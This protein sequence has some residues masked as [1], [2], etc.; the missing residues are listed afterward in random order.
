MTL[1]WAVAALA[2][3]WVVVPGV[4][5]LLRLGRVDLDVEVDDNPG[6]AEPAGTNAAYQDRFRALTALGFR[7][8]GMTTEKAR[9]FTPLHWSWRSKGVRWLISPDRR[10]F[11]GLFRVGGS[12]PWKTCACTL[13]DGGGV[14]ETACSR[15]GINAPDGDLRRIE[16]AEVDPP[17]L[18][19][20]HQAQVERFT[21]ERGSAARVATLRE[22]ALANLALTRRHLPRARVAMGTFP[23]L[24]VFLIPLWSALHLVG[25]GTGPVVPLMICASAATFAVIRWLILPGRVPMYVRFGILAA[26]FAL[27]PRVLFPLMEKRGMSRW[28]D[29]IDAVARKGGPPGALDRLVDRFTDRFGPNECGAVVERFAAPGA[30][31]PTRLALRRILV[32]WNGDDL[33]DS[34]EAWRSW[35]AAQAHQPHGRQHREE[36]LTAP[37]PAAD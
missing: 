2:T 16:I 1:L 18:L 27:L 3:L 19:A 22:I 6:R 37:K 24:M 20:Q 30:A 21:G 25:Q 8:V 36:A 28:L 12:G 33:G 14:V 34:S 9:F 7:P 13:F 32:Q 4:V 26:I 10:T 17:G 15:A 23:I 29:R 31:L 35:C 11:F 5:F